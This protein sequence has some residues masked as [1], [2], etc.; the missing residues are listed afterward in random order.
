MYPIFQPQHKCLSISRLSIIL[1]DRNSL[2]DPS[3]AAHITLYVEG[4]LSE[5]TMS[6]T[7]RMT[8]AISPREFV[9]LWNLLHRKMVSCAASA[10]DLPKCI[11]EVEYTSQLHDQLLFV[12][13]R[14]N[15]DADFFSDL[16]EPLRKTKLEVTTVTR[17]NTISVTV[18]KE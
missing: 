14:V 7:Y 8:A 4:H 17:T 5:M 3:K 16:P 18:N 6:T 2:K 13:D 1:L 9:R 10:T 11:L 15:V 12:V